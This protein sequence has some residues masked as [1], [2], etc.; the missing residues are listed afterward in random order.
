MY[1]SAG[2]VYSAP[3]ATAR[4]SA[5]YAVRYAVPGCAVPANWSLSFTTASISRSDMSGDTSDAL[6]VSNF[7][8]E[9]GDHLS[10]L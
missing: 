8:T 3:T 7:P 9:L 2:N 1:V 10:P 6:Y 5:R 4:R